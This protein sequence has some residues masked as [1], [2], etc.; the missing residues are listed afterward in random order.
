MSRWSR[1]G[2]ARSAASQGF[3]WEEAGKVIDGAALRRG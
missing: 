3:G 1:G 2:P